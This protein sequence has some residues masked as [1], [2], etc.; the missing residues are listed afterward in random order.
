M[1]IVRYTGSS[2]ELDVSLQP[3]PVASHKIHHRIMQHFKVPRISRFQIFEISWSTD[4]D[5]FIPPELL[6]LVANGMSQR[7]GKFFNRVSSSLL[8]S[9][10]SAPM[11]RWGLSIA[12]LI[13][14]CFREFFPDTGLMGAA[15]STG[16]L[17]ASQSS[18]F[19]FPNWATE[20]LSAMLRASLDANLI[21][22]GPALID[23]RTS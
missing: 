11:K 12:S 4:L 1:E 13:R 9:S 2:S 23:P 6:R 16:L 3:C 22:F 14:R 15:T 19:L 10:R 20:G 5:L 18:T 7:V 21:R 17:S 8:Q